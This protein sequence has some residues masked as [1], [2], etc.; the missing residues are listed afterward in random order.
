MDRKSTAKIPDARDFRRRAVD[1]P[2]TPTEL[3]AIMA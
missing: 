3:E 1:G 2:L